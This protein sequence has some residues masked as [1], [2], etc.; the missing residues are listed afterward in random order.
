MASYSLLVKVAQLCLT[1]CDTMD[2]TV[3]G[4]LQAR[5]LEWKVFPSPGD[6]PNRGQNP[7][8]AILYHLSHHRSPEILESVAYPFSSGSC[9]PRNQTVVCCIA[10]GF[11]TSWATREAQESWRRE[12]LL[13]S[14]FWPGEFHWLN[15]PWGHKESDTTE[16]LSVMWF[17]VLP[18]AFNF[19]ILQSNNCQDNFIFSFFGEGKV[20]RYIWLWR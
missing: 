3:P 13:T 7:W 10:G 1:L 16:R 19:S 5:T 11:F 9:W 14:V 17:W 20:T 2:Y 6:L 8:Q 12:R 4:I 15:S 18:Y